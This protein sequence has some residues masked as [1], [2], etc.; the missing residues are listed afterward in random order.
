MRDWTVFG[1]AHDG[2]DMACG[3]K[4]LD[5]IVGRTQNSTHRGRHEDMR[6]ENRK[7]LHLLPLGPQH[8]QSISGRGGFKTNGEEDNLFRGIFKSDGNCIQRRINNANIAAP[9]LGGK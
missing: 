2:A 3:E 1:H 9:R 6:G 7:I 4:A 8:G 5:A